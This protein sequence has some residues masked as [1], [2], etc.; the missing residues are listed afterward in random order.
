LDVGL[1]TPPCKKKIVGKPP[2]NSAGKR[3]KIVEEAK[4][5]QK[6]PSKFPSRGLLGY[7]AV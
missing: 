5:R 1:T 4:E 6:F 2:R 7:E 3:K